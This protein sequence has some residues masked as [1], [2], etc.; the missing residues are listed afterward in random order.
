MNEIWIV[1]QRYVETYFN[2]AKKNELMILQD[3]TFLEHFNLKS[4][5]AF[6]KYFMKNWFI[7]CFSLENAKS[8]HSSWNIILLVV[9]KKNKV[10]PKVCKSFFLT[11]IYKVAKE[12]L[13]ILKS[14]TKEE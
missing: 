14:N 13:K 3:L 11:L 8:P 7:D 1:L 12:Y 9:L 6:D 2:V 4:S 5:S 10:S